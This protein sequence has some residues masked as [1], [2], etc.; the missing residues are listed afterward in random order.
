MEYWDIYDINRQLTGRTMLRNDWNMQPG[1]YHLTV[2]GVIHR[3]SDDTF[4]ITQRVMTKAWAPGAWEIS[5]GGVRAGES[6]GEAVYREILEETGI[7]TSGAAGGYV[8]S[9]RRDN[10]EEK[11]NYFVDIYRYEMEIRESDV[12]LQQEETAG[13]RFA[14]REEIRKLAEQG[15]FLHYDSI[16]RIFED[17]I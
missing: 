3:P 9:Y 7:N 1:D 16:K 11:N 5:G 2:L 6:S 17:A 12:R 14:G 10:P 8:F 13:Y 15:A 4:L